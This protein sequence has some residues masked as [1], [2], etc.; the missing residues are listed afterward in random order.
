[1]LV[2]TRGIDEKIFIGEEVIVTVA[3]VNGNQVQ[4]GIE[5]PKEIP[6]YREENHR[7]LLKEQT[8]K[9]IRAALFPHQ[10]NI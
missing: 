8:T 10:T 4:I 6:V 7:R 9:R 5:A 2:L 3:E 1:M